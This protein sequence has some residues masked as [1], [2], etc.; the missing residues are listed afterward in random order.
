MNTFSSLI[1]RHALVIFFLLAY[2]I[3][4]MLPAFFPLGPFV[5]AL[6][7]AGVTGVFKDLLSR[8]LRWRVGLIW[9]AAAVIAPVAIGPASEFPA[10]CVTP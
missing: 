9:Y 10:Q 5:A 6:I 4:W 3:S 2:A 7:V 8:C 1:Q